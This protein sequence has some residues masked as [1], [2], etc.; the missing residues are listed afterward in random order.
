[1]NKQVFFY[2]ILFTFL[3]LSSCSKDEI[4]DL[5]DQLDPNAKAACTY[6]R[7]QEG[8]EFDYIQTSEFGGEDVEYTVT[9]RG[10][11]S[12]DGNEVMV[13]TSNFPGQEGNEFILGCRGETILVVQEI[14]TGQN[15]Q[16]VTL[17]FQ[18]DKPEGSEYPG[19]T[20]TTEQFGLTNV[21]TYEMVITEKGSTLTVEGK[22][23]TDV[24]TVEL[25]ANLKSY[26]GDGNLVVQQDEAA[27]SEYF[28]APDVCVLQT[29][30]YQADGFGGR[31]LISQQK[32]KD[33][34]Y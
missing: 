27:L 16:T 8:T 5:L 19:P 25:I 17:D 24:V 18:L 1:M 3:L 34:R 12:I 28:F 9:Y 31:T 15:E 29:N 7:A 33:Y 10:G 11:K 23:Y 14:L 20:I 2:P 4:D 26:D 30:V 32:I 13:G 6:F 22:T 21:N